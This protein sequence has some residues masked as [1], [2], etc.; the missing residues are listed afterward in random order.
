MK[1]KFCQLSFRG[2][3][4]PFCAKPFSLTK[5]EGKLFLVPK[6]S[7]PPFAV[8][9]SKPKRGSNPW[10]LRYRCSFTFI[11]RH[12]RVYYELTMWPA[13]SRLDSSVGRALRPY[14]RG[15]GFESRSSLNSFSQGFISQLLKSDFLRRSRIGRHSRNIDFSFISPKHTFGWTYSRKNSLTFQRFILRPQFKKVRNLHL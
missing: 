14:R 11:L 13:P 4:K 3:S 10:P 8:V 2:C 15:R 9:K 12:L 5:I 7:G 6:S 1:T